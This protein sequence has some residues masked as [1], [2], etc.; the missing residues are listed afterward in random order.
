MIINKEPTPLPSSTDPDL[1]Q[2][3]GLLLQKD[4]DRRPTVWGLLEKE[5]L[6]DYVQ[7]FLEKEQQVMLLDDYYKKQ[8][9]TQKKEE[10]EESI[11][12]N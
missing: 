3:T 10:P 2:L 11:Q 8:D 9:V 6:K 1:V 7:K 12:D 4:D 5:Q